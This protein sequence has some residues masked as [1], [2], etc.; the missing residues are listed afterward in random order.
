[1]LKVLNIAFKDL[2]LAFR[3]P[4][5]LVMMLLTPFALTLAVGFAFGGIGGSSSSSGGLADIP[6]VIVNQDPGQF[7]KALV[8]LFQSPDL[9]NLVKPSIVSDP[10]TA[11]R[12]V[13]EDQAAAAVIIPPNFSEAILPAALMQGG[14]S[15]M[16]NIQT[17]KAVVEVYGNPTRTISASVVQSIVDRY[18]GRVTAAQAGVETTFIQLLRSGYLNQNF[19]QAQ[20]EQIGR[21]TGEDVGQAELI[22]INPQSVAVKQKPTVTTLDYMAPSMAIIFLM[23]TVA[24]GGRSILAERD[25]GT[26][27]RLLTTPS[28]VAQ[29]L[30]G[31]ALGIFLTGLAQM[32][33]LLLAGVALLHLNWG[34][35]LLVIA[36]VVALVA[37]ATG[38][39]L[40]IAAFSRSPSQ[41]NAIGTALTLIFS[42]AAGNFAPRMDLPTWLQQVTLATPNGLGLEGFLKLLAGGSLPELS[43]YLLGLA[44]MAGILFVLSAALFRRQYR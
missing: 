13:D 5:A 6:V 41:A 42:A 8:E 28:R 43:P 18:L 10:Q 11:H 19:S 17:Q 15:G 9:A 31:K 22:G 27:P 35:P 12:M 1:M 29:V 24:A 39:G 36:L 3:D 14:F 30:G 2:L 21:Q 4:A 33:I 37:G 23:F 16:Q 34:P 7:G 25:A 32:S 44:A 38:W 26:L 20:G 40:V